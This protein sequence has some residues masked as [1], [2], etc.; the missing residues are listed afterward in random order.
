MLMNIDKLHSFLR[1]ISWCWKGCFYLPG[2][3]THS[4]TPILIGLIIIGAL[5]GVEG[6]WKK[7]LVGAAIM[8]LFFGPMYLIGSYERAKDFLSQNK[9]E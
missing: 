9:K 2:Y 8:A 1:K 4:G 6:G 3:G 5:A 7:S